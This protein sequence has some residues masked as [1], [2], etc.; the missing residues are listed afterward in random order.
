MQDFNNFIDDMEL[1]DF[2]MLDRRF[3]WSNAQ[4]S[5]KWSRIDRFLVH[6]EW[7]D[8]FKL[9]LWGLPRTISDHCPILLMEDGRDWGSKPF[10]FYNFWFTHP[11]SLIKHGMTFKNKGGLPVD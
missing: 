7:V 10:R 11:Y 1:V 4:L 2:P 5:E 9:K 8:K 3:M 6:P